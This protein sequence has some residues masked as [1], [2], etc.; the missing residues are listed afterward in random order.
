M[1]LKKI[2]ELN[3][4]NI[5]VTPE[6]MTYENVYS[7]KE[8]NLELYNKIKSI[9]KYLKSIVEKESDNIDFEDIYGIC[10]GNIDDAFYIGCE[11]G[12]KDGEE[13]L[14]KRILEMLNEK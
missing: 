13:R 8:E 10:G 1:K 9:K 12:I 14:S 11:K 3:M 5:E 7:L 4:S 6:D 2:G